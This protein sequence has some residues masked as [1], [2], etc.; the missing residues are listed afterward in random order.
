M[1]SNQEL[2]IFDYLR[3]YLTAAYTQCGESGVAT[4]GTDKPYQRY[5]MQK[6]YIKT[7]P[8]LNDNDV[9]EEFTNAVVAF[10]VNVKNYDVS[11][12]AGPT[13]KRELNSLIPSI[14]KDLAQRYS[15]ALPS[16]G[17]DTAVQ[18]ALSA[19]ITTTIDGSHNIITLKINSDADAYDKFV[20][21]VKSMENKQITTEDVTNFTNKATLLQTSINAIFNV[22]AA[23]KVSEDGSKPTITSD[24]LKNVVEAELNK[25]LTNA[26][27]NFLNTNYSSPTITGSQPDVNK[28]LEQLKTRNVSSTDMALFNLF[29]DVLDPSGNVV[30]VGAYGSMDTTAN[31]INFKT[32]GGIMVGGSGKLVGG[33]P[34]PRKTFKV[35]N[36][37][38][39]LPKGIKIA[40]GGKVIPV[41][42]GY[43]LRGIFQ[44][45]YDG[46]NLNGVNVNSV[47]KSLNLEAGKLM[48]DI[49]TSSSSV[50]AHIDETDTESIDT[51]L[52]GIWVRTGENSWK[53]KLADGNVVVFTAGTQEFADEMVKE[54]NNCKAVGF[55][56]NPAACRE[57]LQQVASKGDPS[58]LANLA[59]D[60]SEDVTKDVVADLHPKYAL[61]ILKAYGFHRKICRDK[62]AGRQLTKIQN[63]DEWLKTYV[64]KK[65]TNSSDVQKIRDNN[66]FRNFLGLL[67]QLV[68]GNPS[69]LNEWAGE[70][71]ESTGTIEVPT[72]L[73]KRK[74]VS[75]ESKLRGKPHNDWNQI[76]DNMHKVYGNFAR[77]LTFDGMTTNSPFGMDNLFPSVVL[78]TATHIVRGSTWGGAMTGGAEVKPLLMEH[79]S[80]FEYSRNISQIFTEL[81]NGLKASGK[82]LSEAEFASLEQKLASFQNMEKDLFETAR[83]IQLYSQL[84]RILD[85]EKKKET[86][87]ESHIKQYVSKYNHLLDRYERTGSS[88]QTLISILNDCS[89]DGGEGCK[90]DGP[91]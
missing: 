70:T 44:D 78:P 48:E 88:F 40:V 58:A 5:Y 41:D 90:T 79:P 62:I 65:F 80:A 26:V 61:A 23:I 76:K 81:L 64:S 45:A 49:V 9:A 75:V 89:D 13:L 83:N 30:S 25:H 12:N 32:E 37:L 72:D 73:A 47:P 3:G 1:S 66:K 50:S 39:I 86:I 43:E 51:A 63:V 54:A 14:A 42:H 52:K 84:I 34:T 85:A 60:M 17:D 16:A 55:G 71:E 91:A 33:S 74:I 2:A 57:F 22:S 38:P 68:N 87:T 21:L 24:S 35:V 56:S 20:N 28:V 27:T 18:N 69:V 4:C 67:V 46:K 15:A 6:Y 10:A 8:R 77:G 36:F 29:C 31:R 7:N 19:V 11:A 82:T 59:R 53:H